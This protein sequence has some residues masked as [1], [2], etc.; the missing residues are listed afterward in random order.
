[1]PAGINNISNRNLKF[2]TRHSKFRDLGFYCFFYI[3]YIF[4]KFIIEFKFNSAYQ[5]DITAHIL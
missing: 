3:I 1:M 2:Y 5:K 4:Y